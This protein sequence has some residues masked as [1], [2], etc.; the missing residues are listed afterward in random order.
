MHIMQFSKGLYKSRRDTMM[1][2][3]PMYIHYNA[4]AGKEVTVAT[5]Y[6]Q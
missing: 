4:G 2:A 1:Q 6:L 5:I 3:I